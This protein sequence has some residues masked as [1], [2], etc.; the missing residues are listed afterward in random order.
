MGYEHDG[1][2]P[3][4]DDDAT[5]DERTVQGV[6]HLQ[7]AAHEMIEAARAFLDVMED[8]VRDDEKVASVA[9]AFGSIAR[10]AARAARSA[11]NGTGA[12]STGGDGGRDDG[13]QHIRVS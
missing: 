12:P 6:E 11:S 4:N 10:G 8:L 13:V 5:A 3:V 7:A 1:S 9:E 2:E